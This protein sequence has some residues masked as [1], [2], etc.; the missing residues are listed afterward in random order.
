MLR[1]I[2]LE[3]SIR[4]VPVRISGGLNSDQDIIYINRWE[5]PTF[6]IVEDLILFLSTYL[7]K[8]YKKELL[9]NDE[10]IREIRCVDS[11]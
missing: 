3:Y 10:Q 5:I 11:F 2:R 1:H 7:S 6:L 4:Y 8:K 9:D